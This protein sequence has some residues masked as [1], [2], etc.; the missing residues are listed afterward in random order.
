[1]LNG[2]EHELI[3]EMVSSD[4]VIRNLLVKEYPII[5]HFMD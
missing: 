5:L 4:L 1:V 2:V 3:T